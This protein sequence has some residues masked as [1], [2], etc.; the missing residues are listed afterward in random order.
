MYRRI[1]TKSQRARD[2]EYMARRHLLEKATQT[3]IAQ[4][5]GITQATVSRDLAALAKRYGAQS[6]EIVARDR[7]LMIA[8]LLGLLDM[9]L[10]AYKA[11]ITEDRPEGDPRFLNSVK[12]IMAQ[13]AGLGGLEPAKKIAPVMPEGDDLP[14]GGSLPDAERGAAIMAATNQ[15]AKDSI[16]RATEPEGDK[17]QDG[18]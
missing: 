4:E 9:S 11:S 7:S 18:L 8:R 1:R 3:E 2:L 15:M 14:W 13:I 6:Q 10:E 5:L 17:S 16:I 12:G